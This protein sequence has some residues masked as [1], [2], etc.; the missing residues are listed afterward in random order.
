M[1][2]F[3]R[4]IDH[5]IRDLPHK[6]K[7]K[8]S[9]VKVTTR[10]KASINLLNVNNSAG[11]CS[12]SIKFTTDYEHVTPHLT[13]N[14]QGQWVKGQGHSVIWRISTKQEAVLYR[15]V[16]SGSVVGLYLRKM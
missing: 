9:K 3:G 16:D 14:F 13:T 6:F 2:K 4:Y 1:L 12:I 10:R 11:G 7:A 15:T 5:A 8:G